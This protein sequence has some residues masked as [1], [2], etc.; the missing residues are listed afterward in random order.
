ML[1]ARKSQQHFGFTKLPPVSKR[2]EMITLTYI[3]REVRELCEKDYSQLRWGRVWV[4][5]GVSPILL[6]GVLQTV[7]GHLNE[8]LKISQKYL[9]D[10][11]KWIIES[12]KL[13][14]SWNE[15]GV[16][17]CTFNRL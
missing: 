17:F 15:R 16:S 10:T 5:I 13:G 12:I 3:D 1:Q 7:V 4:S 14:S 11:K 2:G 6:S 8:M 9:I